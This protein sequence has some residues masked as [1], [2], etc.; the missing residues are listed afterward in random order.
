MRGQNNAAWLLH[1]GRG[2]GS[3]KM[4]PAPDMS[5]A[6][7][8]D[9][10]CQ[11]A[12][13]HHLSTFYCFESIDTGHLK[14]AFSIPAAP[15]GCCSAAP[16]HKPEPDPGPYSHRSWETALGETWSSHHCQSRV[17]EY[18]ALDMSMCMHAQVCDEPACVC[19]RC[20]REMIQDS[21]DWV[22]TCEIIHRVHKPSREAHQLLELL[23]ADVPLLVPAL[24]LGPLH[25]SHPALG[26]A[27]GQLVLG[28]GCRVWGWEPPCPEGGILTAAQL[29][30]GCRH[31]AQMEEEHAGCAKRKPMMQ[32]CG[33]AQQHPAQC[34]GDTSNASCS[35]SGRLEG[36]T[37]SP[38]SE[39]LLPGRC[40]GCP[41]RQLRRTQA[42]M[43]ACCR[44]VSG[45]AG[46]GRSGAAQDRTFYFLLSMYGC[47]PLR[48]S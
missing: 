27:S 13:S 31:A 2:I 44:P 26:Q 9:P 19:K 37:G 25:H 4:P 10:A 43:Q 29:Q 11:G 20:L 45:T 7:L 47:T 6:A 8:Q 17:T 41:H 22:D 3:V 40:Q 14:W 16:P 32:L 1:V 36:R 48:L 28:L 42:R 39:E 34:K 23:V 35:G 46:V 18:A 30:G 15:C 33:L 5:A 38:V 24:Q 12:D 21:F